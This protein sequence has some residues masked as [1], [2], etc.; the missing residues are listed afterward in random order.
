MQL[1]TIENINPLSLHLTLSTAST[2]VME[3]KVPVT[4]YLQLK[5]LPKEHNEV[6]FP[7]ISLITEAFLLLTSMKHSNK[8]EASCPRLM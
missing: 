2:N 3:G 6:N 7:D 4:A 8:Y 1:Q 5:K